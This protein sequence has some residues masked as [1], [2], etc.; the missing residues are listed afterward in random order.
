MPRKSAWDKGVEVYM[1]MI[2]ENVEPPYT[3]KKLLNGADS[4]KDYS[5]GGCALCYDKDIAATL[6][7]PSELKRSRNGLR[8][9][10]NRETW[11]DVQAR[12]LYQAAQR[13]LYGPNGVS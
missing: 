3:E 8:N 6:C 10:N 7:S 11:L 2:T 12:A 4:W 9:P 5:Y 1:E 13:V